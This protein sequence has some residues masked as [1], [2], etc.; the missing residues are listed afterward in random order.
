MLNSHFNKELS[1]FTTK[2]IN[3]KNEKKKRNKTESQ[4]IHVQYLVHIEKSTN[5]IV[6]GMILLSKRYTKYTTFSLRL[7]VSDLKR[8]IQH[9]FNNCTLQ[10]TRNV[11]CCNILIKVQDI[12]NLIIEK[13]LIQL[14]VKNLSD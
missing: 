6:N 14:I 8:R 11:S 13:Y 7:Q 10:N 5:I 9:N 2:Q 3:N 4:Q 12:Y 1:N